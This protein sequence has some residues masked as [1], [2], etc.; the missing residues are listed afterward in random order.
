MSRNDIAIHYIQERLKGFK[1]EFVDCAVRC[2]NLIV[3]NEEPNGCL[4]DS[5]ALFVCAKEY[6]YEPILCYG[7]CNLDGREFYHAWLEINGTIIDLA[8][9]GN[10]NYGLFSLFGYRTDIPYI[11][12]YKDSVMQYGRFQFDEDWSGA[13]ISRVEGWSFEQY[14]NGLPQNA[15]WKLVCMMLGKTSTKRLIDHLK[16]LVKD[17]YIERK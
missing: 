9:Y 16:T 5:A 8:I 10:V 4:S 3:Q 15:M 7:L 17:E 2:F 12:S 14:M 11:G 13:L 1:P 6:G